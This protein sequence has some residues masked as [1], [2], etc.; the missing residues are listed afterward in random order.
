MLPGGIPFDWVELAC[1]KCGRRR[2][3]IRKARLIQQYGAE[4]GDAA[5]A[6][7]ADY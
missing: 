6:R 1:E 7:A 3:R 2:G 5:S 4:C